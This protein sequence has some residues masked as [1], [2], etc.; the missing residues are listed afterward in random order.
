MSQN[1]G[2]RRQQ[3]AANQQQTIPGDRAALVEHR[4]SLCHRLEQ[5]Y[6]KI[7]RGLADGQDVTAWEDLWISLLREYERIC[8]EIDRAQDLA[9]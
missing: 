7:E 5:G 6:A 9:A 3:A 1:R 4:D 2:T 8:D